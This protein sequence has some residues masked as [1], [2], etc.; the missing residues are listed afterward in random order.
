MAAEENIEILNFVSVDL[1]ACDHAR[2]AWQGRAGGG[3]GFW[4]PG[5]TFA[6]KLLVE[7]KTYVP[8]AVNRVYVSW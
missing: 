1:F 2:G 8:R 3:K 6:T 4:E 7:A 5:Y